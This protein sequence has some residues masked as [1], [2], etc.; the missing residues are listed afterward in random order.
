MPAN[1]PPELF[2]REEASPPPAADAPPAPLADRMR[3]RNLD[4]VVGQPHLLGPGR[5]LRSLVESDELP[6]LLFWGP[7]GSGKTTLARLLAR[8]S[9]ARLESLSAVIAGDRNATRFS[10][11]GENP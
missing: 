4:D 11:V 5:A 3:P 6:S 2:P 7:P 9:A 1:D 10:S 8:E